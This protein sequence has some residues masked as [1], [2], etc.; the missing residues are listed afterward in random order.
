MDLFRRRHED[1]PEYA[2][3]VVSIC[4]ENG[5]LHWANC[6]TILDGWAAVSLGQVDRGIDMLRKGVI[7]WQ[8]GGA[9]LW[10]P[11]F[12]KL[13]AEANAKAGRDGLALELIDQALA[14]CESTGERWALAE[15]LR[16]KASL[17]LPKG[18]GSSSDIESLLLHS[19]EIARYQQARCWELRTSCDLSRF[20]QR[21]GRN[22]EALELLQSVYDQFTEGFDSEDLLDAQKVLRNLRH[23]LR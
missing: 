19:M 23:N 17:L 15:L 1:M 4:N 21:Q 10:L 11:I 13:T 3:L 20:W 8:K 2:G 7:G 18:H 16:I 14:T 22:R 12:S 9:R 6:G 5:F